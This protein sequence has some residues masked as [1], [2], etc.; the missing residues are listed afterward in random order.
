MAE[1]ALPGYQPAVV[2]ARTA[3]AAAGDE[4]LHRQLTVVSD[5]E[6][7]TAVVDLTGSLLALTVD[8]AVRTHTHVLSRQLADVVNSALDRSAEAAI[9]AALAAGLVTEDEEPM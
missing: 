8:A 9:D 7:V 4:A 6:S 1:S 5:D 2:T 3:L